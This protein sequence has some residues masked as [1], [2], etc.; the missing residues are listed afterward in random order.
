MIEELIREMIRVNGEDTR[1][2]AHA[3]KVYGIAKCIAGCEGVSAH[4]QQ[5]VEAA[6]VLH[7]IAIRLCEQKYGSCAGPLQEQEGPGVARPLLQ[8]YTQDTQ[9][10]DRVCWLIAHHHTLKDIRD[11]DHR[12]L[13]EADLIVNAAGRRVHIP[14]RSGAHMSGTSKQPRA[15]SWRNCMLLR[16]GIRMPGAPGR[17]ASSLAM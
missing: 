10:A 7:D 8:K 4:T 1:R 5:T 9:L 6:A 14:R 11:M 17:R 12:I 15:G 16:Q 2:V 3:L 13:V